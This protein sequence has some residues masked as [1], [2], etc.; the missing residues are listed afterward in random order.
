MEDS[1][2]VA[3]GL[4][5]L[6]QLFGLTVSLAIDAECALTMLAND[7]TFHL[8]LADITM[9]G[10]LSGIEIARSLQ[11]SHPRLPVLLTASRL[12]RPGALR[13]RRE[14]ITVLDRQILEQRAGKYHL[15]SQPEESTPQSGNPSR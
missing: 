9:L 8:V 6:L 15:P 5:A 2:E 13:Y 1:G 3:A 10:A 12:R 7:G 4:V 14:H 11:Q